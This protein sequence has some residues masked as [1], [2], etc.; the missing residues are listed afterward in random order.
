M[1]GAVP[2]LARSIV[3]R[4]PLVTRTQR[5]L[6]A[7]RRARAV[8]DG[9]LLTTCYTPVHISRKRLPTTQPRAP[10][11]IPARYIAHNVSITVVLIVVLMPG[12][13]SVVRP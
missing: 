12:G 8:L 4:F 3:Q 11:H 10:V 6:V 1:A 9:M 7:A 5:A 2:G 13:V